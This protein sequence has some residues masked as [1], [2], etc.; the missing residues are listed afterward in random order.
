MK[1]KKPTLLA[2]AGVLLL[3]AGCGSSGGTD[4][5]SNATARVDSSKFREVDAK[6]LAA[7]DKEGT[8][9]VYGEADDDVMTPLIKAF[10]SR[11]PK[12]KVSYISLDPTQNFQRYLSESATGGKT[13]DVIIST[14]GVDYL[15]LVKRGE[16]QDYTPP[17]ATGLPDYAKLAPG[18]FAIEE[19]PVV[20]L[21]NKS[22]LPESKQPKSLDELAKLSET[23]PMKGKVVSYDGTSGIGYMINQAYIKHAGDAGWQVLD[24][25][26]KNSKT[27]ESSATMFTKL[28]QGE[29]A[30]A[31]FVS[32]TA[33]PYITGATA[34]VLNFG[35]LKGG[36]PFIPRG[37][38]VTKHGKSTDAGKVFLSFA[39]STPGQAAGCK[40]GFAPYVDGVECS[41]VSVA[42]V[43]KVIG[44]DD[45]YYAQWDDALVSALPDFVNRWK[46]AFGR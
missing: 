42:D 3:T 45:V 10:E 20:A 27:E 2:I 1:L 8:V 9:V 16:V 46:A 30:A 11:Y 37:I 13:A 21:Y 41:A 14:D 19:N 36:T 31:Y 6:V 26:G 34:K 4:G 22:L 38:G 29:Y 35:Y 39:L 43:T 33:R 23:G 28:A 15:D 24:E 40:G 5:G 7:A 18:V 44:A 12:I 32:G 25:L 17:S